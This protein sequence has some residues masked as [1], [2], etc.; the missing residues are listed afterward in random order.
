MTICIAALIDDGQTDWR[1]DKGAGIA[2]G[3]L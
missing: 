2:A 1:R 3:A